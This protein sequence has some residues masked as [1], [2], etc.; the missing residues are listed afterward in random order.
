M[1]VRSVHEPIFFVRNTA[2]CICTD[3]MRQVNADEE[4]VT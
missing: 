1:G 2:A 4:M 3:R